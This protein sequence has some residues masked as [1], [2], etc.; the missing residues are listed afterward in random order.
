MGI[1]VSESLESQDITISDPPM[2]MH[3]FEFGKL[4]ANHGVGSSYVYKKA[5][6]R[7]VSLFYILRF[8]NV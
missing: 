3:L 5:E 1:K 7:K 6:M 8:K 2:N 4:P